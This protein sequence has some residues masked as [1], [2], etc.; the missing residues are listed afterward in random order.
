MQSNKDK[1]EKPKKELSLLFCV[2]PNQSG[3][4]QSGHWTGYAETKFKG[5]KA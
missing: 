5:L 1:K 2:A 4:H 3:E